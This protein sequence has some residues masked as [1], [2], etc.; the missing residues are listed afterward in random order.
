ML[1]RHGQ[2]PFVAEQRLV[3]D[4]AQRLWVGGDHQVELLAGQGRQ[5]VEVVAAGNVD[6]HLR[7]VVAEA[8]DGRHQP[9]ETAVAFD[10]H[11]QATRLMADQSRHVALGHAHQRQHLLGQYQQPLPRPGEF[12]G[13]RLA[14][15]Q[16]GTQALLEILD[17][18][19]QGRL[20]QVNPLGGLDQ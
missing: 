1:S 7:P 15:E 9:L 18:V 12:D 14:H 17:L 6:F 3:V 16:G 20:G 13:A 10:G 11:V 8:V 4:A 5:R 2:Q 19:R